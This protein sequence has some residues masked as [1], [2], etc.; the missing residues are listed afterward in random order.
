[1]IKNYYSKCQFESMYFNYKL[2]FFL[3][4]CNSIQN[5]TH[6]FHFRLNNTYMTYHHIPYLYFC[7]T[8]KPKNHIYRKRDRFW[9][10]Y[11][12][13]VCKLHHFYFI[14]RYLLHTLLSI[15]IVSI[16]IINN[17][18]IISIFFFKSR[19]QLFCLNPKWNIIF[20]NIFLI[21]RNLS[22]GELFIS[23][24]QS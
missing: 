9:E 17:F 3:I 23:Y 5:Q 1:M 15:S 6:L 4:K 11:L 22:C 19:V 7:N 20:E 2:V 8:Q 16:I 21:I 13:V 18:L 12:I 10:E 14:F 24:C